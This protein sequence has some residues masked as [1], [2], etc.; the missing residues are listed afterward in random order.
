MELVQASYIQILFENNHFFGL[1]ALE[2]VRSYMKTCSVSIYGNEKTR[3]LLRNYKQTEKTAVQIS[4]MDFR[5]RD[6]NQNI[7][8]PRSIRTK[9]CCIKQ[10]VLL[11]AGCRPFSVIGFH[12]IAHNVEAS[13]ILRI[14]S[15]LQV[16]LART[17]STTSW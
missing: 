15:N 5:I 10:F 14:T 7:A 6:M 13:I 12:H 4:S 11:E 2:K 9:R 1:I 8:P 3:K 17:F 16:R